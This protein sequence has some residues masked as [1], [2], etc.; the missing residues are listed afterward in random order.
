MRLTGFSICAGM[1]MLLT[2]GGCGIK[3]E[4]VDPPLKEKADGTKQTVE[5]ARKEDKFPR[6]YP[7]P[8]FD[9]ALKPAPAQ[10]IR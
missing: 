3:P 5:D 7:D 9:P 10:L 1:A 6:T 8:A 2:L 4:F